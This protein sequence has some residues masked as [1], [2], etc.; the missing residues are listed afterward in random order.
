M[1]DGLSQYD[2]ALVCSDLPNSVINGQSLE[3]HEPINLEVARK[4][5]QAYLNYLRSTG[6]KLIEIHPDEH[7]PDCV[8]V[9]DIVIALG[10]KLFLGNLS[11]KTRFK[12]FFNKLN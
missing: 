3:E 10:N 11:A 1:S 7:F 5:H 2:C 8:F 9:E 6:L 4:D 12:L